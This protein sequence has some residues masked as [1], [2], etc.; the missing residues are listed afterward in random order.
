VP[1]VSKLERVTGFRPATPL[2]QIVA[3]VV[4]DQRA[5]LER[6]GGVAVQR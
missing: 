4:A 1:D 3:D 2:R 5:R 6:L